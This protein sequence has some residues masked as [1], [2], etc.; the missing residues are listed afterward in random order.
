MVKRRFHS[1]L[2]TDIHLCDLCVLCGKKYRGGVVST[3]EY[4]INIARRQK[5]RIVFAVGRARRICERTAAHLR[6]RARHPRHAGI[7]TTAV[8][9]AVIIPC[10][11]ASRISHGVAPPE[12]IAVFLWRC[13]AHVALRPVGAVLPQLDA[14]E[15]LRRNRHRER[16]VGEQQRAAERRGEVDYVRIRAR[17]EV[18]LD[19]GRCRG[20]RADDD[21]R[22]GVRGEPPAHRVFNRRPAGVGIRLVEPRHLDGVGRWGPPL[23]RGRLPP[24]LRRA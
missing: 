9:P 18:A 1:F 2:L 15:V 16:G 22:D 12:V 7:V 10:S 20:V 17:D 8:T 19:E 23:R 6:P 13:G 24:R 5:R 11:T 21:L 3:E 4:R 14:A